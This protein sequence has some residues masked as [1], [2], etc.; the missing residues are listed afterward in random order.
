MFTGVIRIQFEERHIRRTIK[1]FGFISYLFCPVAECVEIQLDIK[2]HF[3]LLIAYH[4]EEIYFLYENDIS[5]EK[6]NHLKV[7]ISLSRR[8]GY[9]FGRAF[10]PL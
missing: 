2:C 4:N 10:Q 6:K 5:I 7:M 1:A 3:F 9:P 8:E